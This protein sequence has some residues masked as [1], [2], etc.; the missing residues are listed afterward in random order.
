MHV[1]ATSYRL[2]L[3]EFDKTRKTVCILIF[4][5]R[6]MTQCVNAINANK[7]QAEDFFIWVS[8]KV[9]KRFLAFQ[10][11]RVDK[12]VTCIDEEN[13]AT[14]NATLE[15]FAVAG[16]KR[17]RVYA[18]I[19]KSEIRRLCTLLKVE[20]NAASKK[21]GKGLTPMQRREIENVHRTSEWIC[22]GGEGMETLQTGTA[23][24]VY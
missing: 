11:S 14:L 23:I 13:H 5:K 21:H 6:G 22:L 2:N 3:M 4:T 17:L 18:G 20:L 8:N 12:D 16:V 7:L 10:L 9:P 19:P 1:N 15:S 24:R